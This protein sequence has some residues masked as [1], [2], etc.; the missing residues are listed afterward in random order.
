MTRS[1]DASRLRFAEFLRRRSSLLSVA[2][3]YLLG[4]TG[5]GSTIVTCIHSRDVL[6]RSPIG[7]SARQALRIGKHAG[8]APSKSRNPEAAAQALAQWAGQDP[9]RLTL[10]AEATLALR[11]RGPERIGGFSLS[12]MENEALPVCVLPGALST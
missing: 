2:L 6:V 5:C 1:F 10:A 12:A 7:Q 8:I 11:T 3:V 4:L 9:D